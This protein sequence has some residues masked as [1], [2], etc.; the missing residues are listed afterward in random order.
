M[1]QSCVFSRTN[2]APVWYGLV[3]SHGL[4]IGFWHGIVIFVKFIAQGA[5]ADAQNFSSVGPVASG[6]IQGRINMTLL[7]CRHG[8][9]P[10][11][12]GF[13]IKRPW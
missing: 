10:G 2:Q 12:V 7:Q 1:G 3:L 5:D 6:S 13:R 9:E 4:L 11:R 8:E